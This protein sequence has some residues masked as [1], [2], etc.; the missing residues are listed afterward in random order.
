[1]RRVGRKTLLGLIKLS[2]NC[3]IELF[4]KIIYFTYKR[5]VVNSAK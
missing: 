1:M 4:Y 3:R 5:L 2:Y